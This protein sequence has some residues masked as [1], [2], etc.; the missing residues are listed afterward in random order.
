MEEVTGADRVIV[1]DKGRILGDGTP[2]DIF[3]RIDWLKSIG[4]GP[5][6][7]TEL[8]CRLG[9]EWDIERALETSAGALILLSSIKGFKKSK[10]FLFTGAIGF[11]LLQHALQGWCPPLPIMRKL[12]VRT[13][14]EI[15]NEKT[16]LKI[17]RGDF[18]QPSDNI[19]E[20]LMNAER[21]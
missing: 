7:I 10:C 12:G 13:S 4:L 2:S 5:P 17:L 18:S 9:R 11:F 19:E 1:M 3:R 8:M 14:E 15:Y 20:M 21:Q 16:V 6:K